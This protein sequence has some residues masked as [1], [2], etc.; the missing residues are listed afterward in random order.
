MKLPHAVTETIFP[1]VKKRVVRKLILGQWAYGLVAAMVGL[2]WPTPARADDD[3]AAGSTNHV[4]RPIE[5]LFKTDVVYPQEI[6]ELE[7]ELASVYQNHAGGDTWTIPV[8]LEYGLTDRWQVEAG[9][10]CLAQRFPRDHAAVRGIGDLKAGTQYSFMN[11]GDSSFHIAPRFSV[12]VP[13]GD[14]N[15]DLSG[16]FLQY[17][18]AVIL[19]RDFPELHHTQFFTEIGASFVQRL[20]TPANAADT[21]PAAHEFNWGSGCFVLFPHAAAT[22]EFNWAN[23]TW[24]HHGTENEMY[25][26]PGCL[27]RA[28]RNMEIGLGIPVGLNRGSDRFE[29]IAHVVWEF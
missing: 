23:N 21:P 12:E 22:L 8:S 2:F 1:L 16:G 27:W 25:L 11:I 17:E 15:K 14:V 19:A 3:D 7:V 26:T 10:D 28:R 24:N 6:G 4:E 29:V 13:L 5:E 18:P 9:F 20:H